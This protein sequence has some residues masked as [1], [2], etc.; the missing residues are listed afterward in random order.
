[1]KLI[2]KKII[3]AMTLLVCLVISQNFVVLALENKNLSSQNIS[4]IDDNLRSY[5][6]ENI[7]TETVWINSRVLKNLTQISNI[8]PLDKTNTD[9]K[10]NC[11]VYTFAQKEKT[12]KYYTV[13]DFSFS[14]KIKMSNKDLL[15]INVNDYLLPYSPAKAMLFVKNSTKDKWIARSEPY[16]V[17]SGSIISIYGDQMIH[18]KPYTRLLVSFESDK[19]PSSQFESPQYIVNY[20]NYKS[21]PIYPIILVLSICFSVMITIICIILLK[22]K[23][24]VDN[25]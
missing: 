20:N 22:W 19:N 13:I 9:N 4:A 11:T 5:L 15:E 16:V 8:N 2:L 24:K 18:N 21:F 10:I 1:M 12:L 23:K 17:V 25:T 3:I 14:E 7:P 6:E